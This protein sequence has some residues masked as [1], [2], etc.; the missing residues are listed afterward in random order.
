MAKYSEK[1]ATI[2]REATKNRSQR[3]VAK[4]AGVSQAT[5]GNMVLGLIVSRD[6]CSRVAAA[7]DIPE[8]ELLVAAG[9]WQEPDEVIEIGDTKVEFR[10]TKD[11]FSA[12][13]KEE[14]RQAIEDIIRKQQ[15][16]R[17]GKSV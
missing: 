17:I 7:I 6:I 16:R 1:L 13:E 10:T 11:E 15:S 3:S 9:H 4:E 2:M 12:G 14:I 5:I 8:D